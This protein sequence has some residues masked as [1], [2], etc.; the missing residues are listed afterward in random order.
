MYILDCTE[1]AELCKNLQPF[2]NIIKVFL[3]ILRWSVPVLL[4][5]LGSF[6]MF[7]AVTKAE[8]EKVLQDARRKLIKRIIYGII[9][10][11]V[12][13]IIN[14]IFELI[15]N[16]IP[17]EDAVTSST[18][19]SCWNDTVEGM[20]DCSDI[21]APEKE[22]TPDESGSS[23]EEKGKTCYVWE[24]YTCSVKG[25]EY[26]KDVDGCAKDYYVTDNILNSWYQ[27]VGDIWNY[28]I[29]EIYNDGAVSKAKEY[30]KEKLGKEPK[31][32]YFTNNARPNEYEFKKEEKGNIYFTCVYN[33][34]K[35]KKAEESIPKVSITSKYKEYACSEHECNS[36]SDVLCSFVKE[37]TTKKQ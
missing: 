35:E 27:N 1:A 11:L 33:K 20:N 28:F 16:K 3:Q 25:T 12:P 29:G 6:D 2:L 22:K 26:A 13:F 19:I 4:I 7:N 37:G 17:N 5:A 10:F 30:C 14:L 31:E 9:V 36:S 32:A 18:W 23:V 15:D 24:E 8:D 21:Y 34:Q